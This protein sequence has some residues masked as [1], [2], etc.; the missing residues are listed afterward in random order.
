MNKIVINGIGNTI[1]L[2]SSDSNSRFSMG[3]D[4]NLLLNKKRLLHFTKAS[5]A[6]KK[7]FQV[8]LKSKAN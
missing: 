6:Q 5:D 7:N 1:N 4:G 8:L 3:K 2:C